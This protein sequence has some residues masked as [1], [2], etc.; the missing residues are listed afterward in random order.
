MGEPVMIRWLES[1]VGERRKA[2]KNIIE[3]EQYCRVSWNEKRVDYNTL[4]RE[5]V[6]VV[7]AG[8]HSTT[9]R[10]QDIQKKQRTERK[11]STTLKK[12]K[13]NTANSREKSG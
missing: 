4:H 2:N 8:V 11:L 5:Y 3:L 1:A 12:I 10:K 9:C 7:T 6:I 13:I